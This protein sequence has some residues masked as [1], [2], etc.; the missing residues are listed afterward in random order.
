M[1]TAIHG[2]LISVHDHGILITGSHGIGKSELALGLLDRGHQL[3]AD[4]NPELLERQGRLVGR[5]GKSHRGL[6]HVHGIGILDIP[7]LYG[8]QTIK[9]E[10]PVELCIHLT[11]EKTALIDDDLLDGKWEERIIQQVTIPALILSSPTTRNLPLLV[12]SAV[13]QYL[14]NSSSL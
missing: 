4:D 12:E 2:T 6:L 8:E 1:C 3:V 14:I 11:P 7:R 5:F 10:A 9:D 13:R